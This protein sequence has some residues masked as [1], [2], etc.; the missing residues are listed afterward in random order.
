MT[1]ALAP[2]VRA[3]MRTYFTELDGHLTECQQQIEK[4]IRRQGST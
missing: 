2:F 4:L 1:R 3:Q